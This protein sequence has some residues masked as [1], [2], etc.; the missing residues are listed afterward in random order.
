[1]RDNATFNTYLISASHTTEQESEFGLAYGSE[2]RVTVVQC[3]TFK[4]ALEPGP[5]AR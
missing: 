2:G 3:D 5:R 1:M 4:W